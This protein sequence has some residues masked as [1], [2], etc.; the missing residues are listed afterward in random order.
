MTSRERLTGQSSASGAG[1]VSD[2]A[3]A[4]GALGF[5]GASA[6]LLASLA[7]TQ[8]IPIVTDID[9][10]VIELDSALGANEADTASRAGAEE[11][12]SDERLGAGAAVSD[13]GPHG[14]GGG[15]GGSR[16]A[17]DARTDGLAQEPGTSRAVTRPRMS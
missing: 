13:A 5:T 1:Q 16:H 3:A 7:D 9:P 4:D 12:P 14:S 17:P 10:G 2:A 15:G 11:W 8:P 6:A